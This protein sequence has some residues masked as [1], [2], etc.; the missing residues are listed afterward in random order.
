[1]DETPL[2]VMMVN[3]QDGK[4]AGSQGGILG[5]RPSPQK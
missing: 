3:E 4:R 2:E 5:R 1:M